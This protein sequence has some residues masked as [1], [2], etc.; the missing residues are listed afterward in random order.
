MVFPVVMYGCDSWTIKKAE[1]QRIDAFDLWCW[2]RLLRVLCPS[3]Q[4]RNLQMT[5]RELIPDAKA[6]ESL[7][8]SS[9]WGCHCYRHSGYREE[10]R[11]LGYVAY[12]GSVHKK[13][14][15]FLGRGTSDWSLS[16]KGF[17]VGF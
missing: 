16:F 4:M 1:C 5:T 12:I 7:L 2:R 10:P 13:K 3:L 6:R 17:C 15:E 8:P 14:K 9:S 11:V